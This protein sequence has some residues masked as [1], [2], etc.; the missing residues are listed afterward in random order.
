MVSIDRKMDEPGESCSGQV[1]DH[2]VRVNFWLIGPVDGQRLVPELLS[3][4]HH[5][6]KHYEALKKVKPETGDWFIKSSEFKA[7]KRDGPAFLWLHGS[8]KCF[9]IHCPLADTVSI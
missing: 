4:I 9:F 3:E 8:G 1:K 5:S 6:H 2:R 7:W